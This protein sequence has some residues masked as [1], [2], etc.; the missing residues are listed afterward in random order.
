LITRICVH[1]SSKPYFLARPT[2]PPSQQ[3][4]LPKISLKISDEFGSI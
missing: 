3:H 2:E 1:N 4:I